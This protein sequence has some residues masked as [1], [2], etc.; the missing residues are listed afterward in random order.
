MV[1]RLPL[2][3]PGARVGPATTTL[4]SG[5]ADTSITAGNSAGAGTASAT[6]DHATSSQSVTVTD[7]PSLSIGDVSIAE[8]NSGTHPM[9]FT[10]KLSHNATSKVTVKF[11]TGNGTTKAGSDYVA[12]SGTLTIPAGHTSATISL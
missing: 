12:K 10:V 6:V 1:N 8:G 5:A 2:P 7:K 9:N 11:T 4:V 3:S